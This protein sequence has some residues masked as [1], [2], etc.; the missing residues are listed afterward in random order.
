MK[1]TGSIFS[2]VRT[3]EDAGCI[4]YDFGRHWFGVLEMEAESGRAQEIVIAV[5]EAADGNRINRNPG[6]S[7]IYQEQTV[8]LKPGHNHIAMKM[9]HPGFNGGTLPITPEAVPFRYAEVRGFSGSVNVFQ[10]AYYYEFDDSASDFVS[11]SENLNRIWDL[12][13]HTMKATTPFG[14]FIDGNRE[15]QA[16][17]MD[18]YINQLS[19]F[20]CMSDAEISRK[21]I[22]RLFAFPTWPTEYWM[23]MIPIIH[24]H[25]LYTG[26]VENVRRWYEPMKKKILLDGIDANGLFNAVLLPPAEYTCPAFDRADRK[27]NLHDIVDW[28]AGERDGYEFGTYNLVPN[29]WQ[30]MALGRAARIAS[31]LG[32]PEDA[33]Y[34]AGTAEKL[35]CAIRGAMLKN[36]LFTDNPDSAHTALHSCIFPV[37]WNLA[38]EAE[39]PAILKHMQPKGMACSVFGAQFLLE[40]CYEHRLADY[41]LELMLSDGIRSWNNMLAKGATITMEAWDDIF[42]PNQ[43]WNHPWGA[44]PANI[45]VRYLA[46]IRPLEPG[47]RK[48]MIDP[49]PGALASFAVKT[50]TPH[51][52]VLLEKSTAGSYHLSVPEG[53]EAVFRGKILG[54]GTYEFKED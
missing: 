6:G 8:S 23:A 37:L 38:D 13:K 52:P 15:R 32:K 53:T 18:A 30:Y 33:A 3:I 19:Y 25:A 46:G 36:G 51:G 12:C 54:F 17:E 43:D 26:D 7:R 14:I 34:F 21:T 28:P 39:K 47:F 41:A 49:Q 10:H 42:K 5:G 35:R 2:P 27:V 20:V 24:N 4:F 44:A 50:P 1:K 29:C 48:F 31:S 16:Y 22:D 9:F 11:S 45:I 40:C